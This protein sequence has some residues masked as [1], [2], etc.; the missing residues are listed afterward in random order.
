MVLVS[1]HAF[2]FPVQRTPLALGI[3]KSHLWYGMDMLWNQ[4]PIVCVKCV[5]EWFLVLRIVQSQIQKEGASE[6]N[7]IYL[8]VKLKKS[9]T[10]FVKK[11]NGLSTGRF[12]LLE[13]LTQCQIMGR[14]R[15]GGHEN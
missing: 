8:M 3:L 14:V 1:P 12:M 10:I 9:E 5:Y 2:G 7:T 6:L 4:G 15:R 13:S 11:F